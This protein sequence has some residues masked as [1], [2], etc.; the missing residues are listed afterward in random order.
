MKKLI[1]L[2]L[3]LCFIQIASKNISLSNLKQFCNQ[4]KEQKEKNESDKFRRIALR[5]ILAC[6]QEFI[7]KQKKEFEAS[8]FLNEKINLTA[9]SKF[10]TF[11]QKLVLPDNSKIAMWGD[12]HGSIHSLLKDLEYLKNKNLI[13]EN[14]KITDPNFYMIFLGDYVDRGI[15]GIEVIYTILS[16]KN[17]NPDKVFLVRGNH[18]DIAMN[19]HYG[20]KQELDQKY[21]QPEI[22]EKIS[23]IYHFMPAAIFVGCKDKN[24]KINFIQGCH[25]GIE[26]G[27]NP[28]E[29]LNSN[30]QF[31]TI[32]Q[33]DRKSN[34]EVHF[35]ELI[36][37][38][39]S[40]LKKLRR[41][42]KL[43]DF[44]LSSPTRPHTL[45]LMWHDFI[46]NE[47]NKKGISIPSDVRWQ[48][49]KLATQNYLKW[50]SSRNSKLIKIIR[51]HQHSG[52][53]LKN[54][55]K[56]DGVKELWTTV[57][58]L[59]SAA[60]SNLGFEKNSFIIWYLDED[61]NKWDFEHIVC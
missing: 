27:Y 32:E 30:A 61:P 29:L 20:F 24:K 9:E 6:S 10:Q 45:G 14:L 43:E 47:K 25:G 21:N 52:I 55:I 31:E 19:M 7:S 33:V 11:T 42:R 34:I 56:G 23:S 44:K 49:G 57:T 16:L 46:P 15:Y 4:N 17:Q 13:D 2:I 40:D 53:M 41:K 12:L 60:D 51:A 26:L 35:S 1:H 8:D 39:K 5:F 28:K 50:A 22:I 59:L 38:I 18:E 48:Y 54:L 37:T 58:T 36:P 3:L